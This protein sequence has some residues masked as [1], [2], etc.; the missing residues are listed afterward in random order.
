MSAA[1]DSGFTLLEVLVAL[2]IA[3]ITLMAAMRAGASLANSSAE[4]RARTYAQWSA[5]NRLA[6]IRIS[7][8][9]PPLGIRSW[10][11]SQGPVPLRCREEVLTTPNDAF[12]RVE[13]QVEQLPDGHRLAKLTGFATS[14]QP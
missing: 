13:L 1:R 14:P 7:G 6:Q 10:D 3:A 9:F 12:R 5:E 2:A 4:L 11:C 8:E